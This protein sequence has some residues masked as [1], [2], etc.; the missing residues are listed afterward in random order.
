MVVMFIGG[1]GQ[2]KELNARFLGVGMV[3]IGVS[4]AEIVG[5]DCGDGDGGG[6]GDGDGGN[7]VRTLETAIKYSSHTNINFVQF[8]V[9]KP[10]LVRK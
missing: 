2:G 4:T 5:D 9:S 3:G 6:D 7:E 8:I 10:C 1:K